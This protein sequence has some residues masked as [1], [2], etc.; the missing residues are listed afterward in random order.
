[1]QNECKMK[2]VMTNKLLY[3]LTLLLLSRLL[4][5]CIDERASEG[6][7]DTD[8]LKEVT[9]SV[10]VP[11][12]SSSKTYALAEGDENEVSSIAILLFDGNGNY[13]YRPIYSNAI[14]TD[15]SD[16]KIKTFTIQA[17]EGTYDMVI[18]ANARTSLN[19]ALG[20][21]INSGDPKALVLSQLLLLNSGKWNA[22]PGSAG[23]V[24]IPM[25]GE[26]QGVVISGSMPANKRVSLTRMV[27]KIDLSLTTSAAKSKFN[28]ESVRLYNY[29]DRGQVV[30]Q[31]ANWNSATHVATAPSIPTSAQK[32]SN[33]AGSPLLF[34]GTAI[35]KDPTAPSRGVACLNEIYTFEATAGSSSALSSNTCLVV[36]GVYAG[37]SQATY[38][39]VDLVNTT[40]TETGA[41]VTYLPLL[42]NHQYMM[43]IIDVKGSGFPTPEDA[44]NS[45][46]INIV[47]TV[48]EWNEALITD[49]A[50]DEQYLLGVSAGEFIFSREARTAADDDNT[51]FV[52]TDYPT[53]WRVQK[54]IDTEGNDVN[55]VTNTS[56]G[57]LSLSSTSGA[58]GA[59]VSTRLHLTENSTSQ[60]RTAFIHLIAGR[61][62]YI[63]KVQQS[64]DSKLGLSIIDRNGAPITVLEF[65]STT[66]EVA[67]GTP[68]TTQ[69]FKLLWSPTSS[70]L[71][72]TSTAV[73]NPFIFASGA[74]LSDIPATGNL[75]S[76]SKI[77]TVQPPAITP[78]Q[79]SADPFYER[80]SIYYYNLFVGTTTIN[81]VLT[82]RQYVCNLVADTKTSY[83]LN[84]GTY[85]FRVRSNTD[86][87]IKA[88][89]QTTT[90]GNGS[91]LNLQTSDNLRVGATGGSNTT[92]GD[93]ITF[94]VAENRVNLI[95]KIDVVF[96]STS[97]PQSF[98][99]ITVTLDLRHEYYPDPHTGWAG[100][101]I[102][103]DGSKLTFDDVGDQTHCTYWG[104]YFQWGGLTGISPAGYYYDSTTLLYPPKTSP[105]P[106][107]SREWSTGIPRAT[108]AAI[109]SNPPVGRTE[110]DR[111]YLYE[112]DTTT[113]TGDICKY[114][115]EQAGGRL[116][117]KKWR[118][119]TSNEFETPSSYGN[120]TYGSVPPEAAA[121]GTSS[122][123]SG[124]IKRDIG[125]PFFPAAGGRIFDTGRWNNIGDHS[126]CWSASPCTSFTNTTSYSMYLSSG[127]VMSA[128]DSPR[129]M[130]GHSVRCVTE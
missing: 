37:D 64:I 116:H 55:S 38:Y 114:L 51:L 46:P 97:T 12:K 58:S 108:D 83:W 8:K 27:C 117:G 22:V 6:V 77:Y 85:T 86:W 75:T 18:L 104:V 82:L 123:S 4:C 60:P 13:T 121:D 107:G 5:C 21:S 126:D 11:G 105:E 49:I 87:R 42:R 90:Q 1:M 25:W 66:R 73:N 32:P 35:T 99:D 33:P 14:T 41:T 111:G 88:V 74:G 80:S 67:N 128:Y 30:P 91:L 3:V 50:F 72:F 45:R 47:A 102:Y 17:P 98:N 63:V 76:G 120:W 113:E 34:D 68:P 94:R 106:A 96:E 103:W 24:P 39:R 115:T 26:I 127:S 65:P 23:Y 110:R 78:A 44:F 16:S 40:N 124:R 118:M 84:G 70:D 20:N 10:K 109:S 129:R 89:T 100:S 62:S 7:A 61:L 31:A 15:T 53:G 79:L 119:P 43:S 59:T 130:Y 54:I 101:N 122:I 52:T 28:L 95:G 56:S 57:W 19:N 69:L 2:K 81:K 112:L 71:Y 29:N 9:F 92:E 125:I 48:V 36:G 93:P